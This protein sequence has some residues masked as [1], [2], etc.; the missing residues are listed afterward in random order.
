MNE[1]KFKTYMAAAESM[2]SS[3]SEGYKRGLRRLYHGSNFG[4][5]N[6]H[7]KWMGL[8][9]GR[10]EHGDGYRDGFY[11]RP[12]RGFHGNIGNLNAAGEL[13]L[14]SHLH[15]R[16]NGQAKSSWVKAAQREKLKLSQWVTKHLDKAASQIN[17]DKVMYL[18]TKEFHQHAATQKN[19][20]LNEFSSLDDAKNYVENWILDKDPEISDEK[21]EELLDDMRLDTG[22][23][24][25]AI[26]RAEEAEGY[27]SDRSGSFEFVASGDVS[28]RKLVFR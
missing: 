25:I 7:E 14:D 18:V 9:G 26:R 13:P 2:G 8:G 12:P 16:V 28:A 5:D 11:G 27:T 15:I 17:E 1:N 3:Y 21:L 23:Y 6:E 4:S 10:Q 24:V 19:V 20:V 22:D